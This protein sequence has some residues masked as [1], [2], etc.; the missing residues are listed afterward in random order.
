MYRIYIN[1]ALHYINASFTDPMNSVERW[2]KTSKWVQAQLRPGWKWTTTPTHTTGDA[3]ITLVHW[4]GGWNERNMSAHHFHENKFYNKWNCGKCSACV[5]PLRSAC[6]LAPMIAHFVE[7]PYHPSAPANLW[8]QP[9]DWSSLTIESS[10]FSWKFAF[11]KLNGHTFKPNKNHTSHHFHHLTTS[12][13]TSQSRVL[14]WSVSI[15]RR[16]ELRCPSVL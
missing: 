12:P 6:L 15:S 1:Y 5:V 3:Y 2:Q 4:M 16:L 7:L 13:A 10:P 14:P 11:Q 8:M 9:I